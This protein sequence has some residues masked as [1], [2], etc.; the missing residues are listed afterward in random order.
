[1]AD[2]LQDKEAVKNYYADLLILQY[3]SKPKARETIKTGA[4]IYLGDG[5]IFQLQDILDIDTA[6]G[7]QL[8]IIGKI[9]DCPRIVQ[10]VYNDLKFF[11]FHI[12]SDSL[13]F[14]TV[15]DPTSA[16]FRTIQ[17]YNKSKYSLPDD[18]YRFLLKFKAAVNVMRGSEKDMDEILQNIFNGDVLLKNNH[19]LTITYIVSDR[20]TLAVLAAKV[21]GYYRAPEGI[22]ANYVLKVP[23]PSSIFGFNRKAIINK[24]VAGFSSKGKVRGAT[25]LTKQNLV[26]LVTPNYMTKEITAWQEYNEQHKKYSPITQEAN[27]SQNL[28]R[29]RVIHPSTQNK[30]V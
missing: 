30:S 23:D 14:S 9:L 22:G 18:D 26:S 2:Y 25:F 10:G 29:L 3:H 24:K 28:A 21:L 11:Q 4:D 17:N 8:D 19:D 15:G 20:H 5:L 13:G 7:A 16:T 6:V 1:M 27:K 12:N